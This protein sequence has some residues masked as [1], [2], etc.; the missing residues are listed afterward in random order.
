MNKCYFC[1]CKTC[2]IEQSRCQSRTKFDRCYKHCLSYGEINPIFEC[3]Y[4]KRKPYPIFKVKRKSNHKAITNEV[5]SNKLD[6]ILN[7]LEIEVPEVTAARQ[8]LNPETLCKTCINGYYANEQY[9]CA[10]K[11]QW[12]SNTVCEFYETTT[13][14]KDKEGL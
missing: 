3:D 10:I 5:I 13:L 11:K 12:T 14:F 6:Y 4:F 9:F 7:Y 2:F 1:L 8:L